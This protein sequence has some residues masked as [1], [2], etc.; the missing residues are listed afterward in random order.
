[1]KI[2]LLEI[3]NFRV[4]GEA[5]IRLDN[6]GLVLIQGVNLDDKSASSNGAGKSTIEDAISWVITGET[7]RDDGADDVVNEKVGKDCSVSMTIEDGTETF[8][9]SR[10]RKHSK[11]SNKLA[12]EKL[13]GADVVDI[14]GGTSQITQDRIN[15]IIGCTPK[16]L[17]SSIY[18]GQ[19]KMPNLP[20]MTDKELKAIVEEASGILK[21]EASEKIAKKREMGVMEKVSD[22]NSV[23]KTLKQNIVNHIERL[24]DAENDIKEQIASF[25]RRKE[26]LGE[27]VKEEREKRDKLSREADYILEKAGFRSYASL[28]AAIG[29]AFD[30]AVAARKNINDAKR[31]ENESRQ[32]ITNAAVTLDRAKVALN[33]QKIK[34]VALKSSIESANS[35]VGTPCKSCGKEYHAEDLEGAVNA[36]KKELVEEATKLKLLTANVIDAEK[37]HVDS[38]KLSV[39]MTALDLLMI[40]ALDAEKALESVESSIK[41]RQSAVQVH[42]DGLAKMMDEYHK[43]TPPHRKDCPKIQKLEEELKTM[44]ARMSGLES[45]A[46]K[47]N[48]DLD[49]AL[50]VSKVFSR[51]GIRAHV[52]DTIT[53]F[54]NERTADY[55]STLTDGSITAIWSTLTKTAK[56]ELKEKFQIDVQKINGAKKFKG[57]SGGEK[58]KVRIATSMALNDL[59]ATRASKPIDFMFFDEIDDA[60]DGAGLERLMVILSKKAKDTGTVLVISHNDIASYFSNVITVT[61]NG[62]I[63]T[64][65][66]L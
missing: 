18:F 36:K 46:E 15:S 31:K 34:V 8:R 6:R 50:S 4:I 12:L 53:P 61:N 13:D 24:D 16:V 14:S 43:M 51:A 1:M 42:S 59:V 21:F 30:N 27:K 62:G 17:E 10:Y 37:T 19:E 56:G 66:D 33:S 38:L 35:L 2:K 64:I 28:V 41:I 57:L 39:D 40:K 25:A 23:I 54:L 20:G 22:N 52:L 7:S 48:D 49:V 5:A 29:K 55:L 26:E 60:L 32:K 58:R 63:S 65:E 45:V 11:F 3:N 47:L 44:N 9:I